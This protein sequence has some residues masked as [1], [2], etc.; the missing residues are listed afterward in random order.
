MYSREGTERR[1]IESNSKRPTEDG[2]WL[3]FGS[4]TSGK[5]KLFQ[6]LSHGHR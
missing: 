2:Y 3:A 1:E 4:I 5:K 6:F